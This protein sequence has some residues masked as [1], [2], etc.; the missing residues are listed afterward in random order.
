MTYREKMEELLTA[1]LEKSRKVAMQP[2][3]A[4]CYPI[5]E[6]YTLRVYCYAWMVRNYQVWYNK[7]WE[8][9]C[10]SWT[11]EWIYYEFLEY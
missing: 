5:D 7:T 4:K 3:E 8:C 2:R 1:A 6:E 10:H 11:Y 9:V